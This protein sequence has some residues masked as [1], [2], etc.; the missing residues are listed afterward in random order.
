MTVALGWLLSATSARHNALCVHHELC[1]ERI[2]DFFHDHGQCIRYS[3]FLSENQCF[4]YGAVCKRQN[5]ATNACGFL[6]CT[7]WL[8]VDF[9]LN[10]MTYVDQIRRSRRKGKAVHVYCHE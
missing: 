10:Y 2:Q 9:H 5:K 4:L 8:E 1:K 3:L 6:R 7:E